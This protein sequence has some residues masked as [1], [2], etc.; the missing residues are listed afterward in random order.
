[1]NTKVPKKLFQ[2]KHVSKHHSFP[3]KLLSL[4]VNNHI[5][6]FVIQSNSFFDWIDK[7]N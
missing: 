5:F 1:M 6:R 2:A 7:K 3:E 4:I